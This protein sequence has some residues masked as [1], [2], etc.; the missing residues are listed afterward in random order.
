MQNI[1]QL[2]PRFDPNVIVVSFI[3]KKV[4]CFTL[5]S[6]MHTE[7]SV[8]DA[9]RKS[10]IIPNEYQLAHNQCSTKQSVGLLFI[11]WI[12]L[13]FQISTL[14]LHLWIAKF[15]KKIGVTFAWRLF[16]QEFAL[17]CKST[18]CRW[19]SH[20]YTGPNAYM[21]NWTFTPNRIGWWNKNKEICPKA[22]LQMHIESCW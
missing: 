6:I 22:H 21:W 18:K 7:A 14:I 12:F 3:L 1:I 16:L 5:H 15:G 20:F 17:N 19:S 8:E 11:S 2:L 4:K 9:T 13:T 10:D